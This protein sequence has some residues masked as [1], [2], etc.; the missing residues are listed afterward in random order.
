MTFTY[1]SRTFIYRVKSLYS[2]FL[3]FFGAM[4]DPP[5]KNEQISLRYGNTIYQ[6][7]SIR[8]LI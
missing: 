6:K 1:K 3:A 8:N 2:C 7:N 4:F 5:S